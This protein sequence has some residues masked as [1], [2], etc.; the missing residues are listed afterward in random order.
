MKYR[1]ELVIECM[2]IGAFF[3]LSGA[4]YS[5]S[6]DLSRWTEAT[7]CIFTYLLVL[8]CFADGIWRALKK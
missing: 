3:Y 1:I 6:L 2:L 8:T 5:A 4:F 7:R